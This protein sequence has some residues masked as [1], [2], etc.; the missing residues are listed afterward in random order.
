MNMNYIREIAEALSENHAALMVG[1]GFSKNAEKVSITDKKFLNWNE[2]SDLFYETVYGKEGPGKQYNSS[3]RLAQEVEITVGRP[4]LEKII[5]DAVPDLEYAPS[6]VY[7]K[8]MEMPWKDVFTTNYDTLLERAADKVTNRRYNVV[9][10]QEDLVNSN[11]APRI[12][13]LHGSFPS[14]R[15]FII[16]EEDYRT[17]PVKFAAMVNTVQQALLENVFCMLGFSC[18]DPNFIKWI[19]WIHD[20][21]GKSSSQKIYMVSVTHIAEAKRKLLFERNI[22][23]IDLQELWPDKNIGDRLNSFLEEL[24]LRVEEK[25]RKDNWFD[26]R[27]LHLQYDTD[28]VKKTEIMKKLNES[29]PGW[30]FLPW[31]MK[32]KV[33]YV[34][35]ELD[36]MNEFEHISFTDQVNYIRKIFKGLFE[37]FSLQDQENRIEK[38]LQ[39]PV[40]VDRMSD[41]CDPIVFISKP[42]E[43]YVL[44]IE[45]YNRILF[46]IKQTI[47]E[48]ENEKRQA[49]V[50]RL[51]IL[52]QVIILNEED[53]RYLCK[54]LEKEE[55]LEN[56]SILY[57]LDKQ[58][59]E[60][61]KKEIFED[62]LK[63]MKSDS[64]TQMFS[65]GGNNYRD[66]IGILND[67]DISKINLEE[68]LEVLTN[69]VKTNQSWV[70]RNQPNASERIRQSFL[71]VMGLIILRESKN[72]D[73]SETEKEKVYAYFEALS[74]L[75][76]NSI[77]ID[78]IEAC[79][80]DDSKFYFEDF[81]N[82]IWLS[83]EQELGLIKDFYDVLY[84][85]DFKLQNNDMLLKC[86][87]MLFRISI[88]RVISSEILHNMAALKL[89]YAIIKNEIVLK[90]EIQT[91]LVCLL[92]LQDETVIKQT[93]SEQ[94]ALYKLR[95]R[96]ISCKIAKELY[97]RGIKSDIVDGWKRISENKNEFIEIRNVVFD[98]TGDE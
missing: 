52:A 35:N 62:T 47:K 24:K 83:N 41:Y 32:N 50:N 39:F 21:L 61:N 16:T 54:V 85:N 6:E 67:I 72:I 66:L 22:I 63:R 9:I 80:V 40:D 56:K 8:L 94:E 60:K 4:K 70:E 76:K 87:N 37:A 44:D 5:K 86:S 38:I 10:C 55:T 58:K 43:K 93:D 7:V 19:G 29:Y 64:N 36:N 77:A 81:Q 28:F 74:E 79:F 69:L 3:L 2:L 88:Y 27:Q 95:C 82:K 48:A 92:K 42:R 12:L 23:V 25:R 75:Y 18:E 13:K 46:Q 30:I 73:L 59:Y 45:I 91:L 26:L 17:Y 11:N 97:V 71:I 96:I 68:A 78:M 57:V 15:P 14:Y 98:T 89:C 1:A 33:S 34:L 90:T 49:A 31:K 84:I 20:N 53:L 65:A 51:V